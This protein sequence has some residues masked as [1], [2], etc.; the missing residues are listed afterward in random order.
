MIKIKNIY[1]KYGQHV[2]IKN[3]SYKF[4]KGLYLI[5]GSSGKG[6]TTL[7]NI[8]YGKDKKYEG[9]VQVDEPILYFENKN[10][11]PNNLTV[12]E[13]FN[14]FEHTNR[15]KVE[16]YFGIDYLFKKKIKKLSLGEY[17]LVILNLVL[18]SNHRIIMLDEPLSALSLTNIKKAAMLL[19]KFSNDKLIIIANHNNEYF[20]N[21]TALNLDSYKSKII[22]E[23]ISNDRKKSNKQIPMY[24]YWFYIKKTI[25]KKMIF[26][27]SLIAIVFNYFYIKDYSASITS[28]LL[29]SLQQDDGVIIE[30]ESEVKKISENIFFEIVK[31][32]SK[33]AYDY[34]ANYYNSKLYEQDIAVG[35]YYIDN[36]F[37]LSSV[38]YIEEPLLENEVVLGVNYR[39]F[40]TVNNIANCDENY[41]K[42][43]LVNKK[44]DKY[45]YIIKTVFN[46]EETVIL[47][48]KRFNKIYENNE[49]EEYYFDIKKED[50]EI[51][52]NTINNDDFLLNFIFVKVG[53]NEDSIR[54]IVKESD[55]SGFYYKDINY[56]EYIVC[57]EKGYNCLNYIKY[58]D[59]LIRIDDFED[60]GNVNLKVISESL[61]LDEIVLS[62][63]LAKYLNVEKNDYVTFYFNYNDRIVAINLMVKNIISDD[64]FLVYHNKEWSYYFFKEKVGLESKDMLINNLIV[65]DKVQH[66]HRITES[67]YQKA[68]KTIKRIFDS[69]NN[70][71]SIINIGVSIGSALIV[72][73]IECF[74]NKFRKEYYKFL[75]I[76]SS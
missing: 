72:V 42:I 28:E 3:M 22:K 57:L 29:E 10:S 12:K 15:I 70:V 56:S 53:E 50:E 63:K 44:M 64:K 24:C 74:Y 13:V 52:F 45:K 71:V 20:K 41:L 26:L 39:D 38:K 47:S 27:I 23:N 49:Y 67:E 6:K 7:L 36:G 17:Q 55:T 62:S 2:V 31:K 19:E 8:L 75:C 46:S 37:V 25:V 51:V 1:K 65:Y 9:K 54:Y 30:K 14:L 48:N 16:D 40:C 73:L 35:G 33:Y 11:L 68:L 5:C 60:I 21:F 66:E 69:T 43:L 34:N 32:I 18:N 61:T 58:F 59:S 4:D 76:I